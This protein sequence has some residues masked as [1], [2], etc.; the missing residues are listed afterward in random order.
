MGKPRYV[1][2]DSNIWV[3]LY[4]EDDALHLQAEAVI[5]D[6]DVRGSTVVTNF[7]VQ[8]VFSVLSRV[9]G[10]KK[11]LQFYDFIAHNKVIDL[12]D[13]NSHFLD[14]VIQFIN[15][16]NL[17]KSLGLIDYSVIFFSVL[18]ECPVASFDKLL[19]QSAKKVGVATW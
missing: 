14:Q 7:I 12:I 15:S 19:L 5:K 1:V 8:E 11:A 13:I 18:L 10:Q 2:V 4:S 9:Q 16:R 17:R 3:A 6:I